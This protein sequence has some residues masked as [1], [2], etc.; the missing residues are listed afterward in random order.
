MDKNL[1][2]ER[3]M[4]RLT[5]SLKKLVRKSVGPKHKVVLAFEETAGSERAAYILTHNSLICVT[6]QEDKRLNKTKETVSV[7]RYT[8]ISD[9]REMY[10]H[11]SRISL[12]EL[13]QAVPE[14]GP[15]SLP[16][17]ETGETYRTFL[18]TLFDLV[19]ESQPGNVVSNRE[20]VWVL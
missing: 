19:E 13:Y 1:L 10:Q 9:I 4:D 16:F 7:I 3:G 20:G 14:C 2:H 17:H 6:Y 11:D 5:P 15:V 12:V 8:D 18:R